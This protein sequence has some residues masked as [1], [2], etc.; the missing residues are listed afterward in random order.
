[1]SYQLMN[2][3]PNDATVMRQTDLIEEHQTQ[4]V[5]R[6]LSDDSGHSSASVTSSVSQQGGSSKNDIC[7][8]SL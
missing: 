4:L 1:M 3:V 8:N 2:T 6:Q 7:K 5:P